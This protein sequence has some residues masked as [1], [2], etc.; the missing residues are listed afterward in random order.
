MKRPS[1]EAIE[2][3]IQKERAEALGRVGE[4]LEEALSVL[5]DLRQ[6][7]EEVSGNPRGGS[8]DLEAGGGA[9]RDANR[10]RYRAW[11][12]RVLELRQFL[13]I[14]REAIGL[15]RHDEVDRQYPMPPDLSPSDEPERREPR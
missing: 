15:R 3:E 4:R 7:V 10:A 11:H 1:I 8:R 2:A 13:I 14:Q 5:Q 9:Q 6:G 12:A